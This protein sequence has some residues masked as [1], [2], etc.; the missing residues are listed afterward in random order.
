MHDVEIHGPQNVPSTVPVHA[1][2]MFSRN[3]TNYLLHLI[4]DG[5]LK[6]DLEDEL[7]KGPLVT[8][9]GEVVHEAV[10]AALEA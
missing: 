9:A 5:E 10:R 6:L 2:Q 4:Q 8:H 3:M 1:S 7:T